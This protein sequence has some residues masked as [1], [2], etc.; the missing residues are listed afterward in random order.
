MNSNINVL[1]A[2]IAEEEIQ[3]IS[4]V[5]R[6]GWLTMGS[7]TDQMEAEAA[8]FLGVPEACGVSSCSAGLHM[9][10][11]G[12]GVGPGDEV[13]LSPFTFASAAHAINHCGAKPVLADVLEDTLNL[14]PESVSRSISSKTAA[15]MPI[16]YGGDPVGLDQI[17]N[18][19]LPVVID[20]AHG[21]GARL[22]DRPLE[23]FGTLVCYSFYATKMITSAEGGLVTGTSKI[24]DRIRL[25]RNNGLDMAAH[26]RDSI[27]AYDV[28]SNGFK[29]TLPDV[30]AA[31]A[32]VQLK[33][34]PDFASHRQQLATIYLKRLAALPGLG[35]PKNRPGRVWWLMTVTLPEWIDRGRFRQIL[36]AENI[37][38]TILFV[39]LSRLTWFKDINQPVSLSVTESIADRI[40]SLP[41]HTKLKSKDV[42]RVCDAVEKAFSY[43]N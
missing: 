39:P 18:L 27:G 1:S 31:I 3:A 12:L 4:D 6:S 34:F 17:A 22:H 42:D 10:L 35:L 11:L 30:L 2:D 7:I 9:A 38:T 5:L 15:I 24:I 36:L 25:L 37:A 23:D 28:V 21:F 13:I 8:K 43:L 14:D 29:Y 32:R 20:A 40:V 41:L 19:G 26:K 16:V 33:R